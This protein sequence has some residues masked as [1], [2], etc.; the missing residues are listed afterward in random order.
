MPVT[1]RVLPRPLRWD[2][3]RPVIPSPIPNTGVGRIPKTSAAVAK[4]LPRL[5]LPERWLLPE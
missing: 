2:R 4:P 1:D 3:T 5:V